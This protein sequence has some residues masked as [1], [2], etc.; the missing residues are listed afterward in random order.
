MISYWDS[1]YFI[2]QHYTKF[3]NDKT[4]EGFQRKTKTSKIASIAVAS[5]LWRATEQ[6]GIA[7]SGTGISS[8][9][10]IP[11]QKNY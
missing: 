5:F 2:S 9:L 10:K 11:L 4:K 8:K 3:Q 6:K 1:G 7:E